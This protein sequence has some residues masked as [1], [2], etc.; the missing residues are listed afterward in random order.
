MNT[1]AEETNS[2]MTNEDKTNT[3]KEQTEIKPTTFS[4]FH[5]DSWR[6]ANRNVLVTDE[7]IFAYQYHLEIVER[8]T[9]ELEEARKDWVNFCIKKHRKK[10]DE[11]F[12]ENIRL[13]LESNGRGWEDL[14]LVVNPR[15]S[16]PIDPDDRE[17]CFSLHLDMGINIK[18][19]WIQRALISG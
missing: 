18:D 7:A 6:A 11:C 13:F 9:K 4:F 3:D 19:T 10:F 16:E 2:S 8:K 1:N 14:S 5:S 17:D 12:G 15:T